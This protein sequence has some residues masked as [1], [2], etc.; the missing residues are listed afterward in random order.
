MEPLARLLVVDDDESNRDML[1]RR[2]RKAGYEVESAED[3]RRALDLLGKHVFDL[4]LLDNMM[5]GVSGVEVL[6]RVREK[7]SPCQLP[8]I[9]VTAQCDGASVLAALRQGANDYLTKPMDFPAALA[10]IEIQLKRRWADRIVRREVK[11][12]TTGGGGVSIEGEMGKGS[13]W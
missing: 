12:A 2:L 5:P 11:Q 8:V 10:R 7:H 3:G 6:R 13:N 9:M 4:I 1:S